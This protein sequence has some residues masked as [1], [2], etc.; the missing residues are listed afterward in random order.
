MAMIPERQHKGAP[1]RSLASDAAS[2]PKEPKA[3][4]PPGHLVIGEGLEISGEISRCSTLKVAGSLRASVQ[5]EELVVDPS[6]SFEGEATARKVRIAGRFDGKLTAEAELVVVAGGYIDGEVAYRG[7]QVE[8][9]GII[10]GKMDAIDEAGD[11]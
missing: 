2:A 11:A 1:A 7:L 10:R 8:P 4:Q 3:Q 9:G 5:V 6:G